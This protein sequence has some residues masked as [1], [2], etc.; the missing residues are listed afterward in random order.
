MGK[1][2]ISGRKNVLGYSGLM[3][4][5]VS[6]L[7]EI[8]KDYELKEGEMNEKTREQPK[9]EKEEEKKERK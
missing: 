5:K 8:D 1:N 9:E 7:L 4:E 6:M 2:L 3:M